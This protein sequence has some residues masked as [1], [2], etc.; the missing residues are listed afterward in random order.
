MQVRWSKLISLETEQDQ[1][2]GG[3]RGD[4]E[5]VTRNDKELRLFVQREKLAGGYFCT[6]ANIWVATDRDSAVGSTERV[7]REA[8]DEF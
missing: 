6:A 2:P 4:W 5:G 3:R 8:F 7:I 1:D